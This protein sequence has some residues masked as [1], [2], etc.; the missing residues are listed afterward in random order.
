MQ[1]IF[2][3]TQEELLTKYGVSDHSD[4]FGQ[5]DAIISQKEAQILYRQ[6]FLDAHEQALGSIEAL[7]TAEEEHVT[8]LAAKDVE[9]A[10][11]APLRN[12]YDEMTAKVSS[13][14]ASGDP[15]Q[16]VALGQEFLTP[17][18]ERRRAALQA[19]LAALED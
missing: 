13:V 14:L 9:I 8:A 18:K 7:K 10:A 5:L 6:Q 19:Q 2:K 15:A 11:L 12:L 16:F 4:P 3:M 1:T 17:E